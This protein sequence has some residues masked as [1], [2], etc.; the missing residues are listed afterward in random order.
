[1][2]LRRHARSQIPKYA[3][4]QSVQALNGF[5]NASTKDALHQWQG[6]RLTCS[7]AV[8]NTSNTT[9]LLDTGFWN[10]I[11]KERMSG[12]GDYG[13]LPLLFLWEPF[14]RYKS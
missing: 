5:A 7:Q 10:T 6:T 11:I 14:V 9:I 2:V 12:Q 4:Q 3:T 1:M 8:R 13:V